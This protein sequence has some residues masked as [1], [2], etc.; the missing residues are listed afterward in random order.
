[1]ALAAQRRFVLDPVRFDR[2]RRP[3]NDNGIGLLER[4]GDGARIGFAPG[5]E[6]I[7]PNG[8]AHMFQRGRET[9]RE[10]AV[11]PR[12]AQEERY[13]FVGC[14]CLILH[15]APP[16]ASNGASGGKTVK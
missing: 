6:R 14:T 5:N 8:E 3:Q 9:V 16:R 13:G 7:P 11:G 2:V 1:M 10:G 15:A 4:L 12:V